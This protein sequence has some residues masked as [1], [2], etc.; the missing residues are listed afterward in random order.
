M[1]PA[2]QAQG[3]LGSRVSTIANSLGAYGQAV[4]QWRVDKEMTA[5][6]ST[7]FPNGIHGVEFVGDDI[8]A[9]K[10]IITAAN[11]IGRMAHLIDD[12]GS[13]YYPEILAAMIGTAGPSF[14]LALIA[15]FFRR[16]A[17]TPLDLADRIAAS[18]PAG[19]V[20]V[21]ADSK[22]DELGMM[23]T[24]AGFLPSFGRCSE[25]ASDLDRYQDDYDAFCSDWKTALSAERITATPISTTLLHPALTESI[26]IS[27]CLTITQKTTFKTNETRHLQLAR[28][29]ERG[30]D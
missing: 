23:L 11:P 19:S 20:F 30:H 22:R 17:E 21:M 10:R 14:P 28:P 13:P 18:Y 24:S 26:G 1:I 4:I 16:H 8:F 3:G 27:P 29:C 9:I 5:P 12:I 6:A 2:I 25:M 7:I 15:R